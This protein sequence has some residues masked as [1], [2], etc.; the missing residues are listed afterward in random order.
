MEHYISVVVLRVWFH[1]H[2]WLAPVGNVLAISGW[3]CSMTSARTANC[4]TFSTWNKSFKLLYCSRPLLSFRMYFKISSHFQNFMTKVMWS[5]LEVHL[6]IRENEAEGY[7]NKSFEI[8]I[9][10]FN[11]KLRISWYVEI[12]CLELLFEFYLLNLESRIWYFIWLSSWLKFSW[13]RVVT[14]W[15]CHLGTC[16]RQPKLS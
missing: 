1:K 6:E 7:L 15:L 16:G 11:K 4:L 10:N 13:D 8:S 2:V 5:T 14:L 3:G 12:V 9:F